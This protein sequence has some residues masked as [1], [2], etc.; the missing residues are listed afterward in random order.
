MN[1]QIQFLVN[2][3]YTLLIA[4]VFAEQAGIPVPA[5]PLLLAAGALSGTGQLNPWLAIA[6][7]VAATLVADFLW[8]ELGRRKGVRV[9]Q[10]L[11]KVSLEPD[12]CVRRTENVYA[13]HGARSLLVSKFVPGLSTAAQ[14]L[15][16]IFRMRYS[17]F[18]IFDTLGAVIWVGA[19]FGL[20]YAFSG[21]LERIMAAATRL[22]VWLLYLLITVFVGW[23]GYKY[24]RRQRFIRQLRIDRITS[25]ELKRKLDGGEEVVIVDL[26]GSLDFEAE[27]AMIPGAIHLDVSDLEQV[28]EQL[29]QAPEVILYC[30]C[31]NEVT[32]ARM[33][34]LLRRK[35]VKKIRPLTGGLDGWR[36]QGYPVAQGVDASKVV[37]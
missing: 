29:A 19:F 10:F 16:G 3:G 35:G 2:H 34:L 11:C 21:E 1:P 6:L 37:E 31:P 36:R 20:G 4:W 14:P 13:K 30:N 25:D 12:S 22:G 5:A 33:A 26:R 17:R 7:P 27:P 8:Y 9:L 24:F 28:T 15:A 32:S 18:L 23:I